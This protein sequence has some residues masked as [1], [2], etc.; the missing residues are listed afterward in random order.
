MT[1]RREHVRRR[2][3]WLEKLGR[4]IHFRLVIPL[5]RSPHPPEY[6]ARSVMIGLFW[7]FTPLI[8]VQMYLVGLTWLAARI[9]RNWQF[10]LLLSLAWTWVTNVFTMVPTYYVFYVVGQLLMGRFDAHMGYD[11]FDHAWQAAV[12]TEGFWQKFAVYGRVIATEQG[13]PM[14]VGSIPF[15]VGSAWLGYRWSLKFMIRRRRVQAEKRARAERR[16]IAR[17]AGFAPKRDAEAADRGA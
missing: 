3:S 14:V 5:M 12:S 4:L 13:L 11:N 7:A 16:R 6:I 17:R 1:G 10:S 9:S 15:S 2:F 8:G